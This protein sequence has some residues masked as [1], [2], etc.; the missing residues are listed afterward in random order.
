MVRATFLAALAALSLLLAPIMSEDGAIARADTVAGQDRHAQ[1]MPGKRTLYKRIIT[2][3]KGILRKAPDDSA[4]AIGGEIPAFSIYYVYSQGNG[5][6]EVGINSHG[7]PAGWIKTDFTVDWKQSIVVAFNNQAEAGRARQAFFQDKPTLEAALAANGNG[8]SFASRPGVVAMEPENAINDTRNFYLLPILDH[9]STYFPGD[10]EGNLLQVAS[11]TRN[12]TQRDNS[13]FR[14]GIVFVIDTTLSMDPYILQTKTIVEQISRK[15]QASELAG[16]VSFGLVGFRQSTATN[17]GI[18]YGVKNFLPLREGSDARTFLSAI[19]T[20]KV[21]KVPTRGFREDSIGGMAFAE[22]DNDWRPFKAKYMILITDTGPKAPELGDNY[23]RNLGIAELAGDL[24]DN[25]I[26]LL[27]MH[28]KT[29]DGASD[30]AAAEASYRLASRLNG[31][32]F[33]LYTAIGGRNVDAFGESVSLVANQIVETS[34]DILS[35]RA[36]AQPADTDRSANANVRRAARAFQLEYVGGRQGETAPDFYRAWTID[37]AYGA[38][39]RQALDV[40]LLLT[41][42]QLSTMTANLRAIVDRAN[43][44]GELLD[45]NQFFQQIRELA[46]RVSNDPNQINQNTTLGDAIAEYLDD[47]PYK[48]QT[49]AM[50]QADWV[51]APASQQRDIMNALASKLE[52]YERVHSNPDLWFSLHDGAAAGEY[53]TTISLDRMP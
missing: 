53:V 4:Q 52:Y 38:Y 32:E 12:E 20:M 22:T 35:N 27:V 29:P 14:A 25:G 6:T 33:D 24:H 50:T 8:A 40:R 3:P 10:I 15:L 5:Y 9:A 26:Q 7:A 46:S 2:K 11:V 44:P 31:S 48:S 13:E 47:L 30:H 49:T 51:S 43:R 18:E 39:A 23:V 34:R 21:A 17:P 45:A 36:I 42:N 1:L 28:L 41:K 37:R 19:D 16:K